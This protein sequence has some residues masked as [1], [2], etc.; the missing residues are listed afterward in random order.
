ML[1]SRSRPARVAL[2]LLGLLPALLACSWINQERLG[3]WN[4]VSK[5]PSY[6][7]VGK[8]RFAGRLQETA[9]VLWARIIDF[10]ARPV[11]ED[12]PAYLA[13]TPETG[14]FPIGDEV[15]GFALKKSWVQS[16]PWTLLALVGILF[17]WF[18]PALPGDHQA[19]LRAMGA[20]V[21]SVLVVFALLGFGRHDGLGFNQRYLIDALPLAAL[22]VALLAQS[23]IAKVEEPGIP[24]L[25]G[26]LLGGL[27]PLCV[28]LPLAD[29]SPFRHAWLMWVP[30][31]LAVLL[32]LAWG[33]SDR[34]P[35]GFLFLLGATIGWGGAVHATDDLRVSRNFRLNHLAVGTKLRQVLPGSA[36][37][38]LS[39]A[40][41][42]VLTPLLLEKRDLLGLF[43]S[44]DGAAT[45]H[46]LTQELLDS[47][48]R[49]FVIE[50]NMPRWL[51]QR[52]LAGWSSKVVL[53]P[54]QPL[55]NLALL[56]IFA[57][58]NKED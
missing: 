25:R 47:G 24:L 38:F 30:V 34:R 35:W 56:E 51:L 8:T 58:P 40:Q 45:A 20:A 26:V 44:N 42:S 55:S 7:K 32:L 54:E 6:Q 41:I 48:R 29:T 33:R 5:G 14:A 16:S 57:S 21:W 22:A 12:G 36:A 52:I 31:C 9:W 23:A 15:L 37:V 53:F 27:L 17:S 11:R 18:S 43:A 19:R 50:N 13:P 3:S 2:F 1:F 49:V 46:Q 10:T 4:P 39:P 28:T